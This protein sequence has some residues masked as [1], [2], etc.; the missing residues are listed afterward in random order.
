MILHLFK[1]IYIYI[2]KSLEGI[3]KNVEKFTQFQNYLENTAMDKIDQIPII[4]EF[5]FQWGKTKNKPIVNLQKLDVSY[6]AKYNG[7]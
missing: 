4:M 5:I 7:Q 2:E 3:Y 6:G 1:C